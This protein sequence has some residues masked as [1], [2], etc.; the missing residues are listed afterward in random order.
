V[1]QRDRA[2]FTAQDFV[3]GTLQHGGRKLL[4]RL[5][6]DLFA[7]LLS[8][9]TDQTVAASEL[10]GDVSLPFASAHCIAR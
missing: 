1:L 10:G 9:F 5:R 3:S 4:P 8:G 6:P 2:G 7:Q